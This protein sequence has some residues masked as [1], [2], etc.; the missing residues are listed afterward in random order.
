MAKD[1]SSNVVSLKQN[2]KIARYSTFQRAAV[3]IAL[4]GEDAAR[5][6]IEKLDDVAL[7]R[8][9][10][11]LNDIALM[12]RDVL[13]EIVVDFLGQ[14]R[15]TSGALL[16]GKA[17]TEEL[18]NRIVDARTRPEKL[19][20]IAGEAEPEKPRG[21]KTIWDKVGEKPSEQIA[22]YLNK[23]TPNLISIVMRKMPVTKSSDVMNYMDDTK[24]EAVMGYLVDVSAADPGIDAIVGKMIEM[25][26]LNAEQDTGEE[27]TEHLE[28][29][30][31]LLS[32]IPSN[33]REALMN[34]LKTEHE[35][36]LENIQKS[37]FTIEGIP[38]MLPRNAIP[39]VFREMD[40][41][42]IVKLMG[43]LQGE[44]ADVSEYLLSNISSR[45]A[46]QIRD[47][48]STKGAP[49][50]E[51]VEKIQRDFLTKLMT[52]KRQGKITLS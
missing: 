47:E 2:E 30:G 35:S 41:G 28:A 26:F 6:I 34:F 3:V 33:K 42:D 49:P 37:L 46:E 18:V 23:L 7:K 24:L 38:D 20:S 32:L 51:E 36:K 10:E 21:E 14:L 43:T 17:D 27:K 12:P 39:V 19:G 45:M 25:E 44:F 1:S 16:G 40:Q 13:T 31:E 8:V 4:L 48:M 52:M 15:R 11:A 29:V 9:T 50:E 22:R 5:P